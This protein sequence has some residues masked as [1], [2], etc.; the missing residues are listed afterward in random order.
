MADKFVIEIA[1]PERLLVQTEAIRSQIP[2]KEGYVGVLPGHA[3]LLS[4]MGVGALSYVT[5]DDHRFSVAVS[6]GY[7]EILNDH[8]R[9]LTDM[10]EKGTEIDVNKAEKDLRHANEEII[11]PALSIDIASALFAWK[12]AQARIDAA[13]KAAN[14]EE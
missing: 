11:N 13:R 9:I 5:P 4:E 7:L 1:T 10:A 2:A 6:G 8:V 12:H 3:A 14:H